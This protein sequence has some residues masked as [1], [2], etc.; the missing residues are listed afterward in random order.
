MTPARRQ[1]LDRLKARGEASAAE[2]A[3][4][5]GLTV[6]AARQH[7]AGLERDGLAAHRTEVGG[8]GRPAHRYVLTPAADALFPQRYGELAG[9]VLAHLDELDPDLVPA[10]F[11]RRRRR[12]VEHAL[13]RLEGRPFG[14]RVRELARILDEDGYLADVERVDPRTWRIVE[15]NCAILDVARRYGLACSSELAFL[16]EA[17]PDADIER[18]GHLLAGAHGCAYVVTA[19]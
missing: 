10:V 1:V 5:L 13:A 3:A 19:R 7:L 16:R 11:E 9:E 15:R 2:L 12:R 18:V 6:A 4:D 14:A 17:L 8:R